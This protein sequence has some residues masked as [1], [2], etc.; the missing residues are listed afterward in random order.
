[1]VFLWLTDKEYERSIF[2][3]HVEM[4]FKSHCTLFV[5]VKVI[6][7]YLKTLIAKEALVHPTST[8]MLYIV[9]GYKPLSLDKIAI[10]KGEKGM[11]KAKRINEILSGK[12]YSKCK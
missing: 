5:H 7:G 11:K 12:C 2:S 10:I 8:L 3:I 1:M 9:Y 6:F 4:F